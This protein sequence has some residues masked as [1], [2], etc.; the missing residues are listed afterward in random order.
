MLTA[1]NCGASEGFLIGFQPNLCWVIG[2]EDCRVVLAEVEHVKCSI[3]DTRFLYHAL[4]SPSLR[5]S[6]TSLFRRPSCQTRLCR[7]VTPTFLKVVRHHAAARFTL[8]QCGSVRLPLLPQPIIGPRLCVQQRLI[9][10]VEGRV[11]TVVPTS[12]A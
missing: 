10:H 9:W 12:L 8:V 3:L 11:V 1:N 5:Y 2:D 6:E 7:L 4:T